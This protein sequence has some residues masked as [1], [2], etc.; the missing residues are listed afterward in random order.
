M[1]AAWNRLGANAISYW[2]R[3]ST[4]LAKGSGL[5]RVTFEGFTAITELILDSP[6]QILHALAVH[7]YSC[8][9]KTWRRNHEF[10]STRCSNII[11]F[12]ASSKC[13]VCRLRIAVILN[14]Q[15]SPILFERLICV[16]AGRAPLARIRSK[17]GLSRLGNSR[18]WRKMINIRS[19]LI[20]VGGKRKEGELFLRIT[21]VGR[22]RNIDNRG[23]EWSHVGVDI[24]RRCSYIEPRYKWDPFLFSFFFQSF[25]L[26]RTPINYRLFSFALSLPN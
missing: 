21:P 11:I 2:H 26:T 25:Q 16:F 22:P 24:T 5:P 15:I 12:L 10:I 18:A 19:F 14:I 4:G 17:L 20:W 6:R 1:R 3:L 13:H 7:C 9:A 23:K 8:A